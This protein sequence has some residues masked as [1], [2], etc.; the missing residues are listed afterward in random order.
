MKLSVILSTYQSPAL[1][2]RTLHGYR[3]QT[4]RPLEIVIADDGSG[5]ETAVLV[6][7]ARVR[8]RARPAP[9]L[10][11]GPRLS[12]VRDPQPRDRGGARRLPGVLRRRLHPVG[13]LPRDPRG[14]G[15][16]R[17]V[18]VGRLLPVAARDHRAAHRRGR[19]R[20]APPGRGVAPS[21]RARAKLARAPP[22]RARRAGASARPAHADA[23]DLERAQRVGL[24]GRSA[25]GQR[26]RRAHGL[27]RRGPRAGRAAGDPGTAAAARSA[28][29]RWSCTSGTSAAT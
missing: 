24:E 8:A 23:R 28:I 21:A 14:A 7:Q 13:G 4:L 22:R 15:A 26:L 27:R 18:P 12:Q 11:R 3:R 19:R 9:R 17:V 1:L 25:R 16:P 29:A 10:A 5:P 6:D 2:E 20:W